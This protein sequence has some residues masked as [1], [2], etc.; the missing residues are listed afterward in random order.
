MSGVQKYLSR[1]Q[2]ST[3]RPFPTCA[4]LRGDSPVATLKADFAKFPYVAKSQKLK[5]VSGKSLTLLKAKSTNTLHFANYP[6]QH[7]TEQRWARSAK[8]KPVP[9]KCD[10]CRVC[11]AAQSRNEKKKNDKL[12]ETNHCAPAKGDTTP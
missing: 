9:E 3:G 8:P 11:A 2:Y 1:S 12:T 5:V 7:Y 4:K 6:P 10:V